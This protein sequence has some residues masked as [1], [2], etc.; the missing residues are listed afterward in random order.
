MPVSALSPF[1]YKMV[2][3]T[4]STPFSYRD[5]TTWMEKFSL[6]EDWLNK[7]LVPGTNDALQDYFTQFQEGIANAEGTITQQVAQWTA[8]FATFM[9]N[10]EAE[11]GVLNDDAFAGLI[12]GGTSD[13]YNAVSSLINSNRT[14]LYAGSALGIVGN[15][16]A[17]DTTAIN[18]A[19][20]TAATFGIPLVFD[21]SRTYAITA[22]SF[23]ANLTIQTNGAT[24]K[25]TV[26][27]TTAGIRTNANFRADILKLDVVGGVSN[28][29]GIWISGS[30]TT[31]EWVFVNSLTA[32]QP[33]ANA[34]FVGDTNTANFRTN[35]KI[36]NIGITNWQLPVRVRNVRNSR[37]SNGI[38]QNFIVGLYVQDTI[39]VVFEK[40]EIK[41][42]SA[43]ATGGAGNN[44]VLIEATIADQSVKNL[45]FRDIVVEN[46]AEHSY[47]IGGS[48][49]CQDV[50][51]DRCLSRKPG[52][53]P[54]NLSTGGA[55]YKTLGTVGHEHK[56]IRYI[57]CT[58]EDG[59][60]SGIGGVDNHSAFNL[61][62]IQGLTLENPVVRNNEQPISAM[63][64]LI[65]FACSNVDIINPRFT[66]TQQQAIKL[67][68]DN[69]EV[70]P[71]PGLNNIRIRGGFLDNGTTSVVLTMNPTSAVFKNILIDT[72]MSRGAAAVRCETPTTVGEAVGAYNNVIIGFD[73]VDAPKADGDLTGNPPV[74]SPNSLQTLHYRGPVYGSFGNPSAN[75]GTENNSVTGVRRIRKANAWVTL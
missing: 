3:L 28:D 71:I 62:F 16:I 64:G 63:V 34:L 1:P 23:P 53:K 67:V 15:G 27:S 40:F 25:K 61:G 5:G 66:N 55:G 56:N 38:I 29:L 73:Y 13:T 2:S 8:S 48:F 11:I 10:V 33:G 57:N 58:T 14:A 24:F 41:G 20:I 52:S 51:F 7:T 44:G 42:Q 18:T 30:D 69:V 45:T 36:R 37:F 50:T 68:K 32:D 4:D 75:G 17:D 6:I 60:Y 21:G 72:V 22:L 49:T 39:D 31:I 47:R 59:N 70:F 74:T 9:E 12:N 46:A 43:A 26:N 65:M 19:A 35:I 54:G